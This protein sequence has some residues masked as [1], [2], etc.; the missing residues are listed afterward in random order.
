VAT[1]SAAFN[2]SLTSP[3]YEITL[4]ALTSDPDWDTFRI[5]CRDPE[6]VYPDQIVRGTDHFTISGG[7]FLVT[8]YEFPQFRSVEY[9]LDLYDG[10]VLDHT[11][12]TGTLTG[13]PEAYFV[14]EGSYPVFNSWI[15]S[16][17]QPVLNLPC[18]V[19]KFNIWRR[20]G[21]QL[22]KQNVLGR[23][24]PVVVTD[25]MAGRE[26]QFTFWV[27][28]VLPYPWNE[29]APY[30]EYELLFNEGDILM[31]RCF[32]ENYN[33]IRPM[34]FTVDN[35]DYEVKGRVPGRIHNGQINVGNK[36]KFIYKVTFVEVD[37]PATG[38][39]LL[40]DTT[41]NDVF[42]SSATDWADVL[43]ARSSW[44]DVYQN[45]NI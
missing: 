40:S 9:R 33:G 38:T 24:L 22:A 12:T 13:L 11:E 20:D 15:Q 8:D 26:G 19:E 10:D 28:D 14:A 36:G 45:P 18:H 44:F 41:W 17:E 3:G 31:F 37:R 21:R 35:L 25:V 29:T 32:D 23:K 30:A 6:G 43:A 16:V 34:Y 27:G 7:S 39:I 4:G 2:D 1:I 5:I 42:T